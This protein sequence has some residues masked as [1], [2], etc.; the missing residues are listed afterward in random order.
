MLQSTF[1]EQ[2]LQQDFGVSSLQHFIALQLGGGAAQDTAAQAPA[3]PGFGDLGGQQSAVSHL[4]Q[5]EEC[6]NKFECVD[7][8]N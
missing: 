4:N 3:Q 6:Q 1:F 2:K 7:Y 8:T 5:I